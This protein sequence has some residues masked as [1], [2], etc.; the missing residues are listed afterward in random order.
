MHAGAPQR[1]RQWPLLLAVVIA[2]L[3]WMNLFLIPGTR[4]LL[5]TIFFPHDAPQAA[6]VVPGTIP[7]A[8][9]HL[10]QE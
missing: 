5:L 2:Q 6:P 4:T 1:T 10:P 7:A 8:A 3:L 9:S